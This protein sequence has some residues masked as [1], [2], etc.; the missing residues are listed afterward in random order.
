MSLTNTTFDDYYIC[1]GSGALNN[2]FLGPCRTLAS[3]PNGDNSVNWSTVYPADGVHYTKEDDGATADDDTTYVED[4]TTGHRDLFDYAAVTVLTSI[5][6]VAI[7]TTCKVTDVNAVDLKTVAVSGANEV[8]ATQTISATDY[9][10][11]SHI[12]ET[13]P[14]TSAAWDVTALDAAQFGFEVG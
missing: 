1:D 3:N 7:N 14:N 5:H 13:D 4:A 6:G 2:T 11:V 8:T 12:S 10:T 9:T